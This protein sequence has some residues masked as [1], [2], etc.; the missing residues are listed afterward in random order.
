MSLKNKGADRVPKKKLKTVK[1]LEKLI[2]DNKTILIS[3][4]KSVPA[5]QFQEINKSLRGKAI[6]KVPKKTLI[7]RAIENSDKPNI[8]DIVNFIEGDFAILFSNQETFDLAGDLFKNKSPT[9]AKAGQEAPEDIYIDEGPTDLVPGP[10]VSELGAFGIQIQ[11]EKG[12]IIIKEPK[13]IVKKGKKISQA[14]ADIMG[15]LDIKPFLVGF[16][17]LAAF[18]ETNNKVYSEIKIDQEETL[19]NL[20]SDYGKALAFAVNIGYPTQDTIKFLLAKAEM[21]AKY[22][23]GLNKDNEPKEKVEEEKKDEELKT[24]NN[25]LENK[26]EDK[27]EEKVS[28]ESF[29]DEKSGEDK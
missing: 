10:A 22:L 12:K 20:K 23:S 4:I 14:A 28:K 16:T 6:V 24:E 21:N 17:P 1:E 3:S 18:D 8:K 19:T 15:K 9:K 7:T 2:K 29:E 13:V 11:I 25:T 26:S 27:P 5:S